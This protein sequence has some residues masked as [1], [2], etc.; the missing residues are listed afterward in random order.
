M[1]QE[2]AA[3]EDGDVGM[4]V[5]EGRK[6]SGG[7]RSEARVRGEGWSEAEAKRQF[8]KQAG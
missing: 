3:L 8:D 2:F 4:M 1:Q 6:G 5:Q 7:G